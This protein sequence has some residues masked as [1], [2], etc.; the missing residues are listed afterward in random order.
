M[1]GAILAGNTNLYEKHVIQILQ[2]VIEE[3]TGK[4]EIERMLAKKHSDIWF[5]PF[6]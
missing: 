2:F 4:E 3:I 5:P 1:R 6:A